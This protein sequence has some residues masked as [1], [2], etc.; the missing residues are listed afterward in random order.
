MFCEGLVLKCSVNFWL[1]NCVHT[2]SILD[3]LLLVG[4]ETESHI[5]WPGS[6][7]FSPLGLRNWPLWRASQARPSPGV[8]FSGARGENLG[9]PGQLMWDSVIVQKKLTE[10]S[11]V[12]HKYPHLHGFKKTAFE[13]LEV[14][15]F[16][17]RRPLVFHEFHPIIVLFCTWNDRHRIVE[18]LKDPFMQ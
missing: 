3:W 16:T 1:A 4:E 13:I 17:E 5:S 6:P 8:S 2:V 9:E 10:I 12:K 15:C 14:Y 11:P 18:C 7:R